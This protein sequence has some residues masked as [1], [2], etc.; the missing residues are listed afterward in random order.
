MAEENQNKY[1]ETSETSEVEAK[2]RGLFDFLGKKKEEQKPQEEEVIVTEFEK[3]SVSE[4]PEIKFDEKKKEEKEEEG[5]KKHN[6]LEKLHR[7]NSSSS[8]SSDEEGEDGEKKKKKKKE[9]KGLKEKIEGDH[10]HED[11]TV[12]VEKVEVDYEVDVA[13][14]EEKKGF[15]DKIKEKLPGH[16]KTE[17]VTLTTPTPPPPA[18]SYEYG[19]NTHEGEA[20]E[21][22]G[23][24]EKIKEKLPGYHHKTEEEKQKESAT[25]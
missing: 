9:K 18:S 4:E 24:L 20:K 2:D 22:K 15:L 23:I 12:P 13:E 1:Y 17:E 3:V 11:T 10:K 7:S 14:T 8:S 19:E 5:E 16:K 25:H 6:I 21:K